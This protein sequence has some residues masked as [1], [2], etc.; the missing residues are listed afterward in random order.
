MKLKTPNLIQRADLH[1]YFI[2]LCLASFQISKWSYYINESRYCIKYLFNR[3]C[4]CNIFCVIKEAK[5]LDL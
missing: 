1:K 4:T 3:K 2:F 5:D